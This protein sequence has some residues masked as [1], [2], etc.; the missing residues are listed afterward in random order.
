LLEYQSDALKGI[1][2]IDEVRAARAT[3][4]GR[5][6]PPDGKYEIAHGTVVTTDTP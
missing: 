3:G 1:D 2:N 6:D 5:E 4:C